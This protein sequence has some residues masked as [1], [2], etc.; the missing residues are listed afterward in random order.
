MWQSEEGFA[1]HQALALEAQLTQSKDQAVQRLEQ[2]KQRL[3]DV[4]RVVQ[5]NV[6]RSKEIA[7]HVKADVQTALD[8]LQ[9]QFALGKADARDT[10]EEHRAKIFNALS[11][12][13]SIADQKIDGGGIRVGEA[14]GRSCGTGEH[15]RSGVRSSQAP[16]HGREFAATQCG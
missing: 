12:F 4:V 6:G 3:R 13:E 10:L 7:G 9:V 8:H 5:T 2:G 14:L 16:F 15:P 11:E 1:G